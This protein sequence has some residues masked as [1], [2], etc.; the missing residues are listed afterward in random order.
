M[1]V[2]NVGSDIP[3]IQFGYCVLMLLIFYRVQTD[4]RFATHH[5]RTMHCAPANASPA[6]Q[7]TLLPSIRILNCSENTAAILSRMVQIFE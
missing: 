1:P 7:M 3:T 5:F 2:D 6:F 4:Y